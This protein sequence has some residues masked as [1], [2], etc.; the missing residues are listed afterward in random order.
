MA[1]QSEI[2]RAIAYGDRYLDRLTD[3]VTW[4]GTTI[5]LLK[6][7]PFI[8]IIVYNKGQN[9]WTFPGG[10]QFIAYRDP[11]TG[12][13]MGCIFPSVSIYTEK[14]TGEE[15]EG[16]YD[17]GNRI[18]YDYE[19]L[20][21]CMGGIVIT[22]YGV[23]TV[24]VHYWIDGNDV[25]VDLKFYR[26]F[27]FAAYMGNQLICETYKVDE[28]PSPSEFTF[29][30]PWGAGLRSHRYVIDYDLFMYALYA[31][32]DRP[33]LRSK[34][35]SIFKFLDDNGYRVPSVYDPLYRQTDGL[36]DNWITNLDALLK[37]NDNYK[38]CVERFA[39]GYGDYKFEFPM[40]GPPWADE[41]GKREEPTP[42]F[43]HLSYKSWCRETLRDVSLG[44]RPFDSWLA[45]RA[46][47][48]MNKYGSP[49]A[50]DDLGNSAYD[51][52]I[53]GYKDDQ[54]NSRPPIKANITS[55]GYQ[56]AGSPYYFSPA[57][58]L[59][60]FAELGYGFGDSDAKSI[61]DLL[62]DCLVK[63]QWGYQS[64]FA[65]GRYATNDYGVINRPEHIGGFIKAWTMK[66]GVY[67]AVDV[68]RIM[69]HV[70]S[71]SEVQAFSLF[72]YF[73]GYGF[74]GETPMF[75]PTTSET[76]LAA[77]RALRIYESYKYRM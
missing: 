52:L 68:G 42:Y 77:V 37:V 39:D 53:K 61:A 26:G 67:N 45:M 49:Y 8:P 51:Y 5:T 64:N 12:E 75:M 41:H 48:V 60:A 40:G 56:P 71:I 58:I 1:T 4:K 70:E 20:F 57:Y 66:N 74:V 22:D 11:D 73:D 36:P 21:Y 69:Q 23:P 24:D 14:M 9:F 65:D 10:M 29:R 33:A 25:V 13:Y 18:S 35:Q 55:D 27:P 54:G 28:T 17:F 19:D 50:K 62:A 76:T 7:F 3:T 38:Y 30:F 2:R 34:A 32:Y 44:R 31:W 46:M 72:W 15:W 59:P 43:P 16:T 6:S 63:S 47:H